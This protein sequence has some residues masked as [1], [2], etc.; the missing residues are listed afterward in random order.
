MIFKWFNTGQ[1]GFQQFQPWFPVG[2]LEDPTAP[3]HET[4][5]T[6]DCWD[7]PVFPCLFPIFFQEK[8]G[9]PPTSTKRFRIFRISH[10]EMSR[11]RCVGWGHH[12]LPHDLDVG[13]DHWFA[14]HQLPGGTPLAEKSTRIWRFLWCFFL[15]RMISWGINTINDAI[16][17]HDIWYMMYDI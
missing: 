14:K 6:E 4:K 11:C 8:P 16:H 3:R 2:I 13:E 12:A 10:V 15:L 1:W 9:N 5:R 7:H 17:E